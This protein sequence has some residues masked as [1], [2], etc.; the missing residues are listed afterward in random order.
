MT[1][2]YAGTHFSM[3]ISEDQKLYGWGLNNLGQL[4][5]ENPK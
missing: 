1:E 4:G 3:A 2:V 5:L